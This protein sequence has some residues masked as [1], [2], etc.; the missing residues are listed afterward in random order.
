MTMQAK[1]TFPIFAAAFAGASWLWSSMVSPAPP[2]VCDEGSVPIAWP[3]GVNGFETPRLLS[4]HGQY[5]RFGTDTR[6]VHSGVDAAA[7]VGDEVYAVEDGVVEYTDDTPGSIYREVRIADK[8]EEDAG[9]IYQHLDAILVEEGDTVKRDQA[10]G[11]VVHFDVATGFDHVHLQRVRADGAG[12]SLKSG[13][14][15][16]GDPLGLLAAR[17]DGV[18]PRVLDF[19]AP[20]PPLVR[21]LFYEDDGG[22]ESTDDLA[23]NE[24]AGKSVDIVARVQDVFPGPGPLECGSSVC[25]T[26]EG[27]HELMPR[28]VS[29]SIL[30]ES[31]SASGETTLDRKFHNVIDLTVPVIGDTGSIQLAEYVYRSDS[32]G[33]Y[34][35][36]EFLV[37][38]TNCQE[39]GTGS[40]EFAPGTY[41]FQLL[42]EDASGNVDFLERTLDL[43]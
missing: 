27:A 38:M 30:V 16:D 25:A 2:S 11:T 20:V 5:Q 41:T 13:F 22:I 26:V 37:V 1:R 15:D 36:R 24:V 35:E 10:I 4:S 6:W 31:L 18:P 17:R 14:V 3:V 29:F 28:R 7:C 39:D 12:S 42:L 34:E 33:D 43:H 9:W 19:G 8:D 40:F 21:Y 32:T 23:L